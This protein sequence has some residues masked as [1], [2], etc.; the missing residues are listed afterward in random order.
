MTAADLLTRGF[1]P[2]PLS[3]PFTHCTPCGGY[4]YF[5]LYEAPDRPMFVAACRTCGQLP[6]SEAQLVDAPKANIKKWTAA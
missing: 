4:Q 2:S 6:A 3:G 1:R 5:T